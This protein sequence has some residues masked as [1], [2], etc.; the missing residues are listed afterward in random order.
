[1]PGAR[2][3]ELVKANLE[4]PRADPVSNLYQIREQ[5]DL[6]EAL[7]SIAP[8]RSAV[9]CFC[10]SGAEATRRRSSWRVKPYR[11]AE[12]RGLP[13]LL[14]KTSATLFRQPAS[15]VQAGSTLLSK[16]VG[17]WAIT[18]S[19]NWDPGSGRTPRRSYWNRSRAKAVVLPADRSTFAPCATLHRRRGV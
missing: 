7:A 9:P 3:S 15:E 4:Q 8:S 18:P 13:Q 10:N 19:R 14:Q 5:A 1:M 11:A 6:G 17:S 12:G 2:P 16:N